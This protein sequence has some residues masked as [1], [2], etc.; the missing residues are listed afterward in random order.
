MSVAT[1]NS[2]DE[3]SDENA[4][5]AGVKEEFRG[6]TRDQSPTDASSTADDKP[7]EEVNAM[8]AYKVSSTHHEE[9]LETE[10]KNAG[11]D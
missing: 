1:A 4:A 10:R 6:E 2:G 3:K 11:S 8:A 5:V 9:L 7:K